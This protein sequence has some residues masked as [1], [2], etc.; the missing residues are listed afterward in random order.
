MILTH[1]EIQL[2]FDDITSQPRNPLGG[3]NQG[4]PLSMLLYI[5]YNAPL[6]NIADPRKKEE[7]I[8]GYIDDTTLLASGKTFREAHSTIKQMM[9][10]NNGVFNWSCTYS[11]PL[12]M[13][14]LALVNFSHSQTKTMEAENLT[15]LQTTPGGITTHVLTGKLQA[16]LLGVIMDSKLNWAA[17]HERVRGNA[18]K[19]T[20]A[21]RRY[22]KAVSGICP[23]EV[24]RLY[25]A[26][27][28]PRICYA[29]DIWYKPP[30]K[31]KQTLGA[32]D[33]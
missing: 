30:S 10:R 17:Q 23:M 25:N 27:P 5:L 12:E 4:C 6:I 8:I 7:C 16:K 15:L 33:Q 1:R 32:G 24:V 9:E 31:T 2:I 18:T 22:T 19:F 21:F 29:A 20:A 26:V 11:S 13:N 3:C 28:V 14:K